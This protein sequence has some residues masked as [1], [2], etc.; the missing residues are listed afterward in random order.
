MC[1]CDYVLNS[2]E[3]AH[4]VDLFYERVSRAH[5]HTQS[6]IHIRIVGTKTV[7]NWKSSTPYLVIQVVL[8]VYSIFIC[9]HTQPGIIYH[10]WRLFSLSIWFAVAQHTTSKN[11]CKWW[12]QNDWR[13]IEITKERTQNVKCM[14]GLRN[15]KRNEKTKIKKE[16]YCAEGTQSVFA[17]QL[18]L[19]CVCYFNR[20]V[21]C[22]WVKQH[23]HVY[24]SRIEG[25]IYQHTTRTFTSETKK[26]K[27]FNF[28]SFNNVFFSLSCRYFSF[29][30][31]FI[32]LISVIRVLCTH[33][34]KMKHSHFFFFT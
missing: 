28:F 34:E 20:F 15:N 5:T 21:A 10:T 31:F 16:S 26:T 33:T 24:N 29:F 4:S 6:I 22:V 2:N 30:F 19:G 23:I 1:G 9:T 13:K 7:T 3:G 11:M 14:L 17:V 12:I 32:L 27:I 25:N 18:L 8:N